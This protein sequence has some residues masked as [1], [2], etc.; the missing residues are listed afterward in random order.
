MGR[1]G[2]NTAKKNAGKEKSSGEKRHSKAK[3]GELV[4]A[5]D[6]GTRTIVGIVGQKKGDTFEIVDVAI[7]AHAKRAMRDG[8]IE[9]IDE[10]AKVVKSV[11]D[12]L[13]ERLGIKLSH[14]S[15]AAAGR[16]LK[17]QHVRV[18]ID[19][20]G[21]DSITEEMVRSFE[22]EAV[23]QAQAQLDEAQK[24]KPVSFY[25]VG[26]SIVNYYL[27]DYPIKSF[28]G[29]KGKTAAVDMIAAFLPSIVVESLYA[30]ME[31]NKLEV[32]SLTLEP[33]AAMN[34]II[35][36][37]VRLINIALV[38]IGAGTSDI[39]I[40]KNGSIVA[41]AMATVA[42]DEITE[43]IIKRYLVDFETAENMKLAA[44]SE[45][46]SYKDILGF[47]HS[48]S[49]DEFFKSLYPAL[50]M[51]AETISANI[52]EVNGEAPAAVFLVGGGSK[53]P[54]LSQAV[55][56]KLSIPENRVAVGGH[57]F[58]KN[59]V[60][61]DFNLNG[62]EYV[63]PLGIAVT[64][65]TQQGYDFSIV[66]LNKKK[67]RIF[68]TKSL[69][70]LDLLT[71]A[72]YKSSNII[73]RTGR[74]LTFTLNGEPKTINGEPATPAVITVND[75]PANINT[76]I[77]QGDNVTITPAK[78]GKNA[79]ITVS[80]LTGGEGP[81]NVCISGIDYKF[82]KIAYVNGTRAEGGY[83]IQNFDKVEIKTVSTLGDLIRSMPFDMSN[84]RFYKG[85]LKLSPDYILRDGDMLTVEEIIEPAPAPQPALQAPPKIEERQ[86]IPKPPKEEPKAEN[87]PPKPEPPKQ[88]R[89]PGIRVRLNG[90]Y[91][92]LEPHEDGS[93]NLFLELTALANLDTSRPQG[94]GNIIL[95][96]NGRV[97]NYTDI[98][99]DGDVAVIE[100]EKA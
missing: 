87:P 3:Q 37:E 67:I 48:V 38:D 75:S 16:A 20:E 25:C 32:A 51:L 13:E 34:I 22:L 63:T 56:Q 5:L 54:G 95:T 62:P 83:K 97:A 46:I 9:D 81:K 27:D 77:S 99:Q 7:K 57:N 30:V 89:K 70:V 26:H 65:A 10:V 85:K 44:N 66:T 61:G 72:G 71:I 74:N 33:I 58:L 19:V 17:T 14:V 29:H 24:G 73:G 1:Q 35:P 49:R 91:I 98:L 6:I 52:V 42:G 4:F 86:E 88:V 45:E 82:G 41:Y 64:A 94:T 76:P 23:S 12:E 84:M 80:E 8:Q 59:I 93:P 53:I 90:R 15:I 47:E 69:T 79:E 55:S 36:P 60:T 96:L 40:S 50:D 18:E 78:N 31:K 92:E 39:A 21:K 100:W 2:S 28:V 68:N 11:K 43:E